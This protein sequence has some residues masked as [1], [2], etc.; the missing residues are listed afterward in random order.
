MK[1]LLLFFSAEGVA[2]DFGHGFQGL[3]LPRDSGATA[4]IRVTTG[5]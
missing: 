2:Q 3:G 1:Y 4:N 5:P